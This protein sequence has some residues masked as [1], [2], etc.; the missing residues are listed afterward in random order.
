M[1][2]QTQTNNI[3]A[4]I[5][6]TMR[7]EQRRGTTSPTDDTVVHKDIYD[8]VHVNMQMPEEGNTDRHNTLDRRIIRTMRGHAIQLRTGGSHSHRGTRTT[9]GLHTRVQ[10]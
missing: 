10:L 7:E 2:R 4:Y 6:V 3:P 8:V 9:R 5:L 1:A